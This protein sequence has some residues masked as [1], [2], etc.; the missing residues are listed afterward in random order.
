[1]VNVA[2]PQI[3]FG[4]YKGKNLN[5]IPLDY[6][7]W[8]TN[9]TNRS[10]RTR[11]FQAPKDILDAAEKRISVLNT[12]KNRVENI[13]RVLAGNTDSFAQ[14]N[15]PGNAYIIEMRVPGDDKETNTPE[16]TACESL[17]DAFNALDKRWSWRADEM[18]A[19][20]NVDWIA[21]DPEDSKIY[22]WEVLP[23]GHRKV[24]W[25][26]LGWHWSNELDALN[27]EQGKLPGDDRCLIDFLN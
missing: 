13:E 2:N 5:D 25:A 10:Y 1:M 26:A 3:T 19:P 21:P 24:V 8:M 11:S 4:R 6:L 18:N 23:S 12:E 27:L 17:T 7:M 20:D 16:Y 14:L 9:N 22:I 15:V